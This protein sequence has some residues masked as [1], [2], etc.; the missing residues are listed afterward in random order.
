ML[1]NRHHHSTPLSCIHHLSLL[2]SRIAL[3]KPE[4]A[5]ETEDIIIQAAQTGQIQGQVDEDQLKQLLEKLSEN[6]Q[7]KKT[8]VTVRVLEGRA[9]MRGV[10][11]FSHN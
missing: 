5:R 4:R 9:A 3:V 1:Q 7:G 2:V 11:I 10:I 8:K 6:E